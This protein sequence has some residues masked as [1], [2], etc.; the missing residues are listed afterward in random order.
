[1]EAEYQG[2]IIE[3]EPEIVERAKTDDAAF[4]IL[5]NHYFPKI[6]GYI[7]KRVGH[8]ETTE[9]LV[10]A[11]FIKVFSNLKNYQYQNCSFGAW[12]YRIATNNL[13]D[14]YRKQGRKKEVNI[15]N[16]EEMASLDTSPEEVAKLAENRQTVKLV[17]ARLPQRQAEVIN[18]K[19]FAELSNIEIAAT[20]GIS[21]NNAG[22]L[23]HRA[24]KQFD[25][26]YKK[27]GQ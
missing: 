27:Y 17:M 5:Y 13:I 21:V 4:A 15:D 20:L 1:M 22:V 6:Y 7:F 16:I 9:D 3:N 10:S 8:K 18:L 2:A 12:I 11:T 19:F 25:N 23:I 24:I 14:Y 26:F